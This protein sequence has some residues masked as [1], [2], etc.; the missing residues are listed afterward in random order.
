VIRTVVTEQ[1]VVDDVEALALLLD[2]QPVVVGDKAGF[3]AMK[4]GCGYPMG[5]FELL[6]AVGQDVSLSIQCT[7]YQEFREPGFAPPPLLEHLV[8]AG[9]LGRKTGRGFR[10][11]GCP[12]MP[13]PRLSPPVIM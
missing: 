13:P 12:R 2:K 3:I 10:T 11:Y 4:A 1:S 9:Y 6:D 5:P 7:L 8:T